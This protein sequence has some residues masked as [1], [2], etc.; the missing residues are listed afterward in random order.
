VPELVGLGE[1]FVPEIVHWELVA[2]PVPDGA[3]PADHV[4]LVLSARYTRF[5]AAS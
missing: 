4:V 1:E 2:L 3:K 5:E